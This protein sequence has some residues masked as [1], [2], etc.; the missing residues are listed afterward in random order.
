VTTLTT[1]AADLVRKAVYALAR[2]FTLSD[3]AGY[4]AALRY[5]G[6]NVGPSSAR[7]S[8]TTALQLSVVFACV[9]L[10][11]ENVATLPLI[12][13]RRKNGGGREVAAD[14]PLYALLHDS[15]NADM[16]ATEFWELVVAY[17]V[18]RGRCFVLKEY[19]ADGAPF[20]F[21]PL[22]FDRMGTI[23]VLRN[24]AL[25]YPY[26]DPI[27]GPVV[28]TEDD[29]WEVKGFCGM[30]VIQYG[31]KSM[32]AASAAEGA[33]SGLFDRDMRPNAVITRDEILTKDQRAMW[34]QAIED[35]M[36]STTAGGGS[37]RL[38]EGGVKYQQLSMSAED[39]QLLQT[40]QYS[41]EDLCRWF[42]V[43]PAMIG[44]GTAVSNWGTGREQINLGFL[45][46][47]LR[48]HLKRLEQGICKSLLRPEERRRIYAEFSVEGLARADTAGR[49]QFYATAVQ[50]GWMTRNEVRDLENL[51]TKD[52]GDELTVQSN[53][54]PVTLLGQGIEPAGD[55]IDALKRAL[56]IE[57]KDHA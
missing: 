57:E 17:V 31:A 16:T 48:P 39:A 4:Q 28:Y 10:I 43:P 53:L 36:A 46:Y 35:G 54:V 32:A 20:A 3:R 37:V 7:V 15:P 24:G 25:E 45:Q 49:A 51:P 47:V 14:H 22:D 13:Y 19:G 38:L 9:K 52:G 2:P 5:M 12:I 42:G 21:T 44:H 55:A 18:L 56:G 50:N 11:A 41:T 26:N 8:Q 30:S 1:R 23:R 34:K 27:K 29:I 6:I 40:R 33:A